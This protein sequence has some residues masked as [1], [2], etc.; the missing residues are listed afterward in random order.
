M[1]T[2]A[3]SYH[4]IIFAKKKSLRHLICIK[5]DNSQKFKVIDGIADFPIELFILKKEFDYT[6]NPKVGKKIHLLRCEIFSYLLKK[7]KINE[8]YKLLRTFYDL[9]IGR[10]NIFLLKKI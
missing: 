8:F 7:K 4:K 1:K 5:V 2:C 3:I 10:D 9:D 6:N